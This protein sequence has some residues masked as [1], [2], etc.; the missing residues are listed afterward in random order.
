MTLENKLQQTQEIL[1]KRAE[2]L[3][4]PIN[5]LETKTQDIQVVVF[6]LDKEKYGI[7]TIYFREVFRFKELTLLPKVPPFIAGVINVRRKIISVIDLRVIFNLPQENEQA[8]HFALILANTEMEFA[9]LADS[10]EGIRFLNL[11]IIYHP[12]TITDNRQEFIKGITSDQLILLD[13]E[14]LLKNKNLIVDE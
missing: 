13:G 7:E 10:I 9:L 8:G 5:L 14:K 4:Q 3:A 11:E 2:Q 6:H 1:K 12:P